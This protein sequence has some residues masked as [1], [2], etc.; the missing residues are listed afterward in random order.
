MQLQFAPRWMFS[1]LQ[2]LAGLIAPMVYATTLTTF[3]PAEAGIYETVYWLGIPTACF[4]ALA[5]VS[6]WVRGDQFRVSNSGMWSAAV[7]G[8]LSFVLPAALL[9]LT[10][11]ANYSGGGANIGVAFLVVAMPGYLPVAMAVGFVVGEYFFRRR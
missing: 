2:I 4:L 3:S 8:Y 6:L 7:A 10:T 5:W 11:G 9:W 1:I